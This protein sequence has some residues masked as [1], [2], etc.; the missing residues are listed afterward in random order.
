VPKGRAGALR[1]AS[2]LLE[3]AKAD[4]SVRRSLNAAG[5]KDAE[6][7]PASASR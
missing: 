7:A 3:Q 5:F 1:L 6:V 2:Q 4:G